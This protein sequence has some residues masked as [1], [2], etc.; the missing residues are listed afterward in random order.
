MIDAFAVSVE[1]VLAQEGGFSDDPHDPGGATN[2]GISHKAY[3]T[4]D[5][6]ALTRERAIELYRRD[7]WEAA[8][9]DRLP[10]AIACVVFDTA[11]NMGVQTAV[12]MLQASLGIVQDGVVGP[13]TV[14][15]ATTADLQDLLPAILARRAYRYGRMSAFPRFGLGWLRRCFALQQAALTLKG[16]P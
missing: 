10:P 6:R 15:V 7:Y 9:C 5:I 13:V 3:P 4:E 12:T 2:L 8:R 14:Q 16:D 11:V 1:F